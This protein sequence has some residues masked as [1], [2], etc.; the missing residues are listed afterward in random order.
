MLDRPVRLGVGCGTRADFRPG[1]F[2][3]GYRQKTYEK[4][5]L[6]LIAF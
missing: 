4:W 5:Y 3:H 2:L 6:W 1:C